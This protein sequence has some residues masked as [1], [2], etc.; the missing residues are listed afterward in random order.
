MSEET[1]IIELTEENIESMIC[2]IRDQRVMLDFDLAKIYGYDTKYLNRQVQRNIE[3]FPKDFMFQLTRDET[4]QLVRS[5]FVTARKSAIESEDFMKCQFGTSQKS[6]GEPE[7][8]TMPKKSAS[9]GKQILKCQNVTSSWGGTRKPPYAFTEQ[10]IYMLMTV[11]KGELAVKQSKA[12]IRLFKRMKDYIVENKE[13]IGYNASFI[14]NRFL[15]YDKKFMEV[16]EKLKIV[17]DNFIDPST[18]KSFLI[19]DGQKIEADIAYQTIYTLAESSIY[20]IDDYIGIKT[21]HLLMAADKNVKVII[22]SDNASRNPVQ[23][24]YIEDFKEETGIDLML[25]PSNNRCHDRFI[26][27][28]YGTDKERIYLCG[29]SSKDAGNKI[30]TIIEMDKTSIN[31]SLI[32]SLLEQI[33]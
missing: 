32:D 29:S 30:T 6:L 26:V 12:L 27:I 5:Q 31:H 22:V 9:S 25:K 15:S 13:L 18:H 7:D 14:N 2:V 1:T 16:D 28:D 4:K 24:E 10:G 8:L 33:S 21:L 23:P 17:M 11:L 19:L 3:K 20:I